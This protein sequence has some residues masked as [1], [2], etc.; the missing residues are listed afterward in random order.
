M[1][2]GS[3]SI[4]MLI[5]R[6]NPRESRRATSAPSGLSRSSTAV[7]VIHGS[8]SMTSMRAEGTTP[9]S[10]APS[11]SSLPCD[12]VGFHN[13]DSGNDLCRRAPSEGSGTNP[14]P[15]PKRESGERHTA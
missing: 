12:T 10:T 8:P 1:T 11:V 7:P 9:M 13:S 5:H 6:K 2:S 15:P 3:V 4:M 14:P